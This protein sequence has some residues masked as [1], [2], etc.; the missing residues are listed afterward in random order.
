M[1]SKVHP[2]P[3]LWLVFHVPSCPCCCCK[4]ALVVYDWADPVEAS[5]SAPAS[6]AIATGCTCTAPSSLAPVLSL[7]T[8]RVL[9]RSTHTQPTKQSLLSVDCGGLAAAAGSSAAALKAQV[10]VTVWYP[11]TFRADASDPDKVL[12]SLLP[13]NVP[14]ASASS[15][16]DRWGV[17]VCGCACAVSASSCPRPFTPG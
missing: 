9:L 3:Y 6:A 4:Q 13:V 11:G 17:Y 10:A 12:S 7:D 1:S 2:L 8:C 16:S 14:A 5:L 15:C